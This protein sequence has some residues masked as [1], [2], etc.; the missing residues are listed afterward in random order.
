MAGLTLG[1]FV[2]G[3]LAQSGPPPALIADQIR[4]EAGTDQLIATGNVEVLFQGRV[5]TA[6]QIIYDN[7]T[8]RLL[9]SGPLLLQESGT[10]TLLA[11]VAELDAATEV[12]IIQGARLVLSQ[13][14][15]FAAQEARSHKDGRIQLYRT[16][17]S[18]CQ[19]CA[20]TQTPLWLIRAERIV[21]DP[22][23]LQ[24]YVQNAYFDVMGVTVAYLPYFRFPDPELKRATGFLTPQFRNSDVFGLGVRVPYFIV[25]NDQ[26]DVTLT[27]FLTSGGA[28]ILEA[29]YRHWFRDGSLTVEGIVGAEQLSGQPETR[30]YFAIRGDHT[31]PDD[32][33]LDA[34]IEWAGDTGFLKTYGYSD[35]DRLDRTI[36]IS[37]QRATERFETSIA[38]F[39][40]LRAGDDQRTIPYV[41]PEIRYQRYWD[42]AA[43]GRLDVTAFS[44]TLIRE[45]G[46]DV[47]K[48][49]AAATYSH[50]VTLPG[51]VVARGFAGVDAAAYVTEDDPAFPT[52][53]VTIFA[54][55]A[56][57]EIRWPLASQVGGALQVLEPV[58]QVVYSEVHGDTSAVPNEDS[59]ATEFDAANLFSLNRFPG[60]DRREEG[61]RVNLG[62]TY[63]WIDPSGWN[64][65]LTLGQVF[66]TDP[67][68]GFGVG[69]GLNGS[70]SNIVAATNL[71]L[72]P[73]FQLSNQTLFDETFTFFRNDVQAELTLDKFDA[74]LSYIYLIPDQQTGGAALSQEITTSAVYRF[75]PNWAAEGLWQR[76]IEAG[77]NVRMAG[78]LTF[79][80]ECLNLKFS[81]S[82][83]FTESSNVPAST[84]FGLVLGFVGLG[85][86][87]EDAGP[88]AG[89]IR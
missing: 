42:T 79:K 84:E 15:Q 56:G 83:R 53:P 12:G 9:A 62:G 29:E 1:G 80:N 58:A 36:T 38:A 10:A 22:D 37:R 35:T 21:R 30:G 46:R 68:T 72:P 48:A 82:R 87:S 17:G 8:E 6:E 45:R 3:A 85:S 50:R 26:S 2:P 73:Y 89:C 81:V 49:Q 61:L 64:A 57:A 78:A 27:P 54:P 34:S 24:I 75:H 88:A 65:G 76:D 41:L 44:S 4:Y 25:L 66:R 23:E 59:L 20:E 7:R 74:S 5:L 33:R 11:D 47:A 77:R 40:S 63:Q 67:T 31:L 16:V 69:T 39:Q 86:P 60:I 71:D 18:S 70:T 55:T 51:G 14:F 28:R 19:V 32:F 52:S 13:N 43:S